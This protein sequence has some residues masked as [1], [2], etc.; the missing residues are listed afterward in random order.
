[1]ACALHVPLGYA[2]RPPN[3]LALPRSPLCAVVIFPLK[4]PAAAE[5][6]RSAST[7]VGGLTADTST[8]VEECGHS[9]RLTRT[10]QI[11]YGSKHADL[12]FVQLDSAI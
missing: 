7:D 10:L 4:S 2:P 12:S 1:L 3:K 6:V 9:H 8:Q 11:S 5:T